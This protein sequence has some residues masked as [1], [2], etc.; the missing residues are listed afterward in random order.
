MRKSFTIFLDNLRHAQTPAYGFIPEA[1]L[2]DICGYKVLNS[3]SIEDI[4]K[5]YRE[6]HLMN[7]FQEGIVREIWDA[8]INEPD[9]STE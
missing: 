9:D 4:V 8:Y 1:M 3:G 5:H 7:D 6:K 2:F